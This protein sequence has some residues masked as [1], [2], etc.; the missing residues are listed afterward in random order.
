MPT[1]PDTSR[2]SGEAEISLPVQTVFLI[3]VFLKSYLIRII[4]RMENV[5]TKRRSPERRSD[6]TGT[7][8]KRKIR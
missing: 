2:T 6:S 3:L 7:E 5:D 4:N 8:L 1:T